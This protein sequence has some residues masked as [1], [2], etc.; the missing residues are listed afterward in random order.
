MFVEGPSPLYRSMK[1]LPVIRE[2]KGY[3]VAQYFN[4]SLENPRDGARSIENGV[5]LV[6][7]VTH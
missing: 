4:K 3:D 5:I 2:V 7:I 6:S 1:N